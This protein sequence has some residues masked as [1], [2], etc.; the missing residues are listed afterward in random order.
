MKMFRHNCRSSR[1]S[2]RA[3]P[4]HALPRHAEPSRAMLVANRN[5]RTLA[6]PRRATPHLALPCRAAPHHASRTSERANPSHDGALSAKFPTWIAIQSVSDRAIGSHVSPDGS[7]GDYF[8]PDF[9]GRAAAKN[10]VPYP[11]VVDL[12]NQRGSHR[13]FSV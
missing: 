3:N 2:E 6:R 10:V 13:H 1:T 11:F 8:L 7:R 5:R 12:F 4:C 9:D